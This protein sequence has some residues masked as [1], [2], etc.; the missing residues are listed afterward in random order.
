MRLSE[1]AGSS[2]GFFFLFFVAPAARSGCLIG[3]SGGCFFDSD[4]DLG[5]GWEPED[6]PRASDSR[7]SSF[8]YLKGGYFLS[9]TP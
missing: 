9:F 5:Q 3:K 7:G 1:F 6:W 8:P 2:D 4:L